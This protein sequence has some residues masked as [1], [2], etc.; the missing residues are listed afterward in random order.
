[1]AYENQLRKVRIHELFKEHTTRF[2]KDLTPAA[3]D[4]ILF[5]LVE[6]S[7]QDKNA[8]LVLNEAGELTLS[9]KDGSTIFG[10]DHRP[11]NPAMF[12]KQSL[13]ENKVLEESNQQQQSQPSQQSN[14]E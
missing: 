6:N 3:R 4:E 11:W 12:V 13:L 10:A 8:Q 2:D 7:L 14:N 1:M 5:S 9:G